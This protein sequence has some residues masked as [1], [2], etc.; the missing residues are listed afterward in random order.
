MKIAVAA[1]QDLFVRGGAEA[2]LSN[3]CAALVRAGHEVE[4]VRLPFRWSPNSEVLRQVYQWRMIDLHATGADLVITTKFPSF[5]VKA[6]RKVAWVLHQHR[7]LY[8]CF[9]LPDYSTFSSSSED[10]AAIRDAVRRW[11]TEYLGES[12][13]IFANSQ[14]VSRRLMKFNDLPSEVLYHPPPSASE[15][16]SGPFGDYVFLP[17]RLEANKRP[18]LLAEALAQTKK[19]VRA[20]LVGRGPQ[21]E[22]VLEAAR[23]L[24]VEDRL[25]I[26]G[27]V[28][29]AERVQLYAGALAVFYPPYDEDLGYVTLEA[30]LAEK[31]VVTLTD[32]GG[33]TEFVRNG[34]NGVV[35]ST[36]ARAAQA[37][38]AYFSDRDLARSHGAAGRATYAEM[39]PSWDEVCRRLVDA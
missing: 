14:T 37:F 10:D 5:Y 34:R 20:I 32:A 30:F 23:R 17:T 25:E 16:R 33:P 15:M 12:R 22:R 39:I 3:L 11:D 28:S 2:H 8:D 27:Y 1:V 4:L 21:K 9:D 6:P 26:R 13:R 29:D 35:A 31:P 24:G 19:P 7:P 36:L 18:W 38:D